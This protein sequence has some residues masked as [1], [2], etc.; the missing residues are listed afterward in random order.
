L[1]GGEIDTK[2][3][4]ILPVTGLNLGFLNN[5]T[6]GF[7]YLHGNYGTL[8]TTLGN[9]T[10]LQLITGQKVTTD[11]VMAKMTIP[12]GGPMLTPDSKIRFWQDR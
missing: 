9:P 8:T 3:G 2:L 11:S 6:V 4:A 10:Q 5:A 7:Q 12:L 1:F